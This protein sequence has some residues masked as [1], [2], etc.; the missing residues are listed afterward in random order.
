MFN[1][2]GSKHNSKIILLNGKEIATKYV[3]VKND[4]L[5]YATTLDTLSVSLTTIERVEIAQ[6]GK[7]ITSGLLAGATSFI[8]FILAV[9]S[10]SG[11]DGFGIIL[12][13]PIGMVFGVAGLIFGLKNGGNTEYIFNNKSEYQQ[14]EY[15]KKYHQRK[16]ERDSTN[17]G[18]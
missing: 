13:I 3:F 8:V 12:A 1:N 18:G 15:Y 5:Y 10:V 11:G 2:L 9:G 16:A 14:I 17:L 7:K 4:S 6:T